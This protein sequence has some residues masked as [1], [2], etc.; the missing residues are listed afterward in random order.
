MSVVKD[1]IHVTQM[2]N[3]QIMRAVTPVL[4]MKATQGLGSLAQVN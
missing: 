4:V 3:A 1:P 2:Q